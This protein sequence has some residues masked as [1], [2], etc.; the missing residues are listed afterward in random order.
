MTSNAPTR[1]PPRGSPCIRTTR[2]LNYNLA[3]YA[4]MAGRRE[5]ALRHLEIAF[6]GNPQTREWAAGDSDLDAPLDL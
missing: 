6:A 4:A 5:D 3:C 1:S 2:S